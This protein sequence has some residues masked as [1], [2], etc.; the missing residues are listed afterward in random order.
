M[1]IR[2]NCKHKTRFK[3]YLYIITK[4]IGSFTSQTSFPVLKE[5]HY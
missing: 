2:Y 3:A 4:P 5:L 1:I